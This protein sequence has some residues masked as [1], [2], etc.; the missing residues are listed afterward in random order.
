MMIPAACSNTG[1][2]GPDDLKVTDSGITGTVMIGPLNPVSHQNSAPDTAPLAATIQ[3][4]DAQDN[5][6]ATTES[7]ED[8]GTFRL[9]LPPGTY[10]L[11]PQAFEQIYPRASPQ[12]VV[13][14]AGLFTQVTIDYDT[15]IR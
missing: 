11:I 14:E 9:T 2:V 3:V 6:V 8:D 13:V 12:E 7:A 1:T 5:L 10:T 15:G 4:K